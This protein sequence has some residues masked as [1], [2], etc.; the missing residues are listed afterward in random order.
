[1][2]FWNWFLAWYLIGFFTCFLYL[3]ADYIKGGRI[4]YSDIPMTFVCSLLGPLFTLFCIINFF[5]EHGN[6]IMFQK[7][8]KTEKK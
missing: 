4:T 7:K 6:D 2:T 8:S 3:W 5:D 1:M